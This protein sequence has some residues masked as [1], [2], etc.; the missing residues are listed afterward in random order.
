MSH[1]SL[2]TRVSAGAAMLLV[3]G[4]VGCAPTTEHAARRTTTTSP[5]PSTMLTEPGDILALA[6]LT[7]PPGATDTTATSFPPAHEY[8]S[9]VYLVTFTAPADQVEEFTR[10]AY[11]VPPQSFLPITTEQLNDD[12]QRLGITSVPDGS[13]EASHS[14][15]T[16]GGRG[17][18]VTVVEG[19]DLTTVRVGLYA[20]TR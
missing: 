7:L 13:Y 5:E 4:L 18:L 20:N 10:A 15:D 14:I 12:H 19:P 11:G 16:V 17:N 6:D 8:Q 3:L 9:Y 2:R 1:N